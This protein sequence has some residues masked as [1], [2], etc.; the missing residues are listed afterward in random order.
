MNLY[1]VPFKAVAELTY[2]CNITCKYCHNPI[3]KS[4]FNDELSTDDWF[5][6]LE[7]AANLGATQVSLTGGEPLLRKDLFEIAEKAVSLDLLTALITNGSLLNKEIVQKLSEIGV[8]QAQVSLP[9]PSGSLEQIITGY[10]NFENRVATITELIDNGIATI[11]NTVLTRQNTDSL[12]EIMALAENLGIDSLVF[13]WVYLFGHAFANRKE[14][15]PTEDQIMFA[16]NHLANTEARIPIVHPNRDYKVDMPK[17]CRWGYYTLTVT[18]NGFVT[19]CEPASVMY[20]DIQFDSVLDRSIKDI[21]DTSAVLHRFDGLEWLPDICQRCPV[22]KECHGGCRV[23]SYLLLG[24]ETLEDPTC[25]ISPNH[26]VV[27]DMTW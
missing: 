23:Y 21:L 4:L 14:I 27:D 17:P 6:V 11:A 15:L 7:Q 8:F 1:D 2:R 19:P 13:Q 18:P 5:N 25:K 16:E 10:D 20:P 26:G 12:P 3:N 22:I 9:A 24:D